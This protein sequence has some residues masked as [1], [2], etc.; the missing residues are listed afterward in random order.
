MRT[1]LVLFALVIGIIATSGCIDGQE[2]PETPDEDL[3]EPVP[4]EPVE[5]EI[6]QEPMP[7]ELEDDVEEEPLP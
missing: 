7:E 2:A 6:E 4:E 1:E 5:E 3:E